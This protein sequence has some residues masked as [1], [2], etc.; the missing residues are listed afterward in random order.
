MWIYGINTVNT[1]LVKRP[2]GVRE[3]LI[4]KA[5]DVVKDQKDPN[6]KVNDLINMAEKKGIKV[7]F[8]GGYDICERTGIKEDANHQR[9]A[10]LIEPKPT[11]VLKDLLE[12]HGHGKNRLFLMIDSVTDPNNLGAIIRT[13][14][15]FGVEVIILPKD[16]S[17]QIKDDVYKTSGGAVEDMDFCVEIN[18][19][20]SVELLKE[21][22]FWVY[23][24][25]EDAE[26]KINEADLKGN[27]CCIIGGEDTGIRKLLTQNCDMLLNIS[28]SK[29]VQSLNVSVS[30]GIILYEVQ[31]QR[32]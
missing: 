6:S 4:V 7:T 31:R 23:G 26:K 17:A 5:K 13:A 27:V 24:F 8:V 10:A 19:V 29:K 1:V 32:L 12:T 2:Q 3:I 21:K 14:V 11:L 16:R 15:A 25:E 9:V 30:A 20:R 28:I 18:L 22:G